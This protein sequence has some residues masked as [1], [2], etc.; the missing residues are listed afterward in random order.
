MGELAIITGASRGIGAAIAKKL[1]QD[2]YDVVL[3]CVSNVAK[4]E[5]VAEE[6]R[7]FGV[8]AVAKAW[9]VADYDACKTAL[10]EI[11]KELG[12]PAVLV[13]NAGI[14][15]DGLLIRMKPEQFDAVISANLKGCF[16]MLSLVS[17]MM[18]R[19]KR[20]RIVNI[21]SVTGLHG[22][23]GQVNYAAAKAGVI[24]MTKTAAKELGARGITVNA[25]APGFIETDMTDVLSDDIKEGA[26]KQIPLGHFGKPED[27][28]GAAAFLASDSASYVTGQVLV[29]DGGLAM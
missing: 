16:N 25:I 24:G 17:A 18:V 3:N 22:N 15:R 26:N 6:C 27:I 19:A 7:A 1:A 11:K 8:T 29:V 5:A 28:A 21:A 4:A 10:A 12:V 2:G 20:G 13:N 9:D 14:T 23:A